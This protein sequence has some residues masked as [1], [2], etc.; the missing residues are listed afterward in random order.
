MNLLSILLP[1][2]LV[3]SGVR[4]SPSKYKAHDASLVLQVSGFFETHDGPTPNPKP[5][6]LMNSSTTGALKIR[7][8]L[9]HA[10]HNK[11]LKANARHGRCF[12]CGLVEEP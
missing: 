5:K 8:P 4:P 9:P 3:S 6:A 12:S 1:S 10:D 11:L 2:V 7:S